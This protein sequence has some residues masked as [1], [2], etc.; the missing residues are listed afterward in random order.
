M[1]KF[2]LIVRADIEK[3]KKIPENERYA[4]WPDMLG[5]VNALVD[6]GIRLDGAPLSLS[7]KLV[8]KNEVLSDGPF[9]ESKEAILGYDIILADNF[10]HAVA[11]AGTCP[12]VL[13]GLAIRDVRSISPTK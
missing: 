8:S 2:M 13:H 11:I 7:G 5:W 10:E 6:S 1:E 9:I 4:D 12:M 3:L